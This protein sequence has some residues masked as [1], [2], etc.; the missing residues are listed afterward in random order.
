MGL[1]LAAVFLTTGVVSHAAPAAGPPALSLPIQ[2]VLGQTCWISKFVDLDPGPGVLDYMCAGRAND[3]HSGVDIAVRDMAAMEEGVVVRAAA[4]GVVLGARDGVPDISIKESGDENMSG[5][6]CGNGV[7]VSHGDGWVTQ[8]C[9][10]REGSISVR[11]GDKVDV[12]QKLGLVGLSGR[13]EYPHLHFM[14]RHGDTIV[15]PFLG[16][17]GRPDG[18]SC[19]LGA[20]PLWTEPALNA[21]AYTPAAIFNA[22]FAG[23]VPRAQDVRNGAYRNLALAGDVP[24]LPG[25]AGDAPTGEDGR[26]RPDH[27]FS[28]APDAPVLVFWTEIFG[29]EKGDTLSMRLTGPGGVTLAET[30]KPIGKREARWFQFIGKKRHGAPWP[31]G[32][33]RG[34]VRVTGE[35]NG[36][37]LETSAM[38][39]LEVR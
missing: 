29:I 39:T 16:V 4:A 36:R 11:K 21:L 10:M 38:R 18:A 28:F 9:H 7:A 22:G 2:C 1:G 24:A 27:Q 13:T 6:G 12:G 25:S 30:A 23:E 5:S 14:V 3:R 33:Y 32:T 20:H 8:Y 35:R 34:E 17:E 31:A 37:M 26:G 15:D 19:G